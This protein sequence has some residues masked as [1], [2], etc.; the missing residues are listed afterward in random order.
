MAAQSLFSW[1]VTWTHLGIPNWIVLG[2]PTGVITCP[3]VGALGRGR[4]GS[5]PYHLL[6]SIR[7]FTLDLA[8]FP[9]LYRWAK[10]KD[11]YRWTVFWHR[12]LQGLGGEL[13]HGWTVV[14]LR[15]HAPLA[16]QRC[17]APAMVGMLH[18]GLAWLD[19]PRE[20]T[21]AGVCEK[22]M[23]LKCRRIQNFINTVQAK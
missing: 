16:G 1:L 3:E 4:L 21:K 13:G 22:L 20:V 19:F 14:N 8:W 2:N 6:I 18:W 17:S 15:T 10:W 12:Y 9:L 11:Y 7:S 5:A 23:N